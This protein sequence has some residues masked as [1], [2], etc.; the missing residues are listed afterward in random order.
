M[1]LRKSGRGVPPC[2]FQEKKTGKAAKA[3]RGT[4]KVAV[5]RG[6][7]LSSD[8]VVAS[9]Y[10]QK[11]FYM[12]SHSCES[13]T[14]VPVMKKVWSSTL[15]K[16]VDFNFL[17]W[18]LS[19]DYNYEIND[20][21]IADQL[22]LVYRFMR[23]QRNIKWWWALFLWGYE[24]S[25]VNSY[26]SYKWHCEL[27]GVRKKKPPEKMTAAAKSTSAED[28]A[29]RVDSQALSPTRGRLKIRLNHKTA[30]HQPVP[31]PGEKPVCQLHRWAHKEFNPNDVPN[32]KPAGS[33]A[34]VMRCEACG[35]NLCLRCSKIF[36]TQQRLRLHVPAILGE[37]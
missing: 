29:P 31:A 37:K 5:L 36:H 33:R 6:D 2:V 17:H 1:E 11:P 34:H 30:N 19:N 3:A 22:R 14:W 10:V 9:C 12:I 25:M 13:V 21:D 15:K 26:I 35:V 23:F 20:N 8:L 7:S 27:K 28:R 32:N 24:V 18:N 4:V 16:T